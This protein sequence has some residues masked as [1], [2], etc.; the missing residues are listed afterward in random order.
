M[1]EAPP[2]MFELFDT[3]NAG[4]FDGSL[5]RPKLGVQNW[6]GHLA[7]YIP[8]V[9]M[10]WIH[11]RTAQQDRKYVADSL[12]HEMVHY[13][14]EAETGDHVQ[15]HGNAFVERANKIGVSTRP[16][17]PGT[18]R[19]RRTRMAAVPA[20]IGLRS[21]AQRT[22]APSSRRYDSVRER[23]RS[24]NRRRAHGFPGPVELV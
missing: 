9:R 12:L 21:V 8:K 2:W 15:D 13:A 5:P 4:H 17:C 1:A 19:R 11:P 23:I 10:I 7:A 22:V 6:L 14:L 24:A 18:G 16:A 3:L 20:P